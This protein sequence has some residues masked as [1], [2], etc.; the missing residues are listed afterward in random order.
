MPV[1]HAHTIKAGTASKLLLLYAREASG[2]GL[3]KTGLRH[4]TPGARAGYIREGARQARP[5]PLAPGRVGDHDPGGFVE[6]DRELLPG[7]YQFGAPD[8]L[9]AE[10]AA[11]AM[12]LLRFPGATIDPVEIHLVGYDPQDADRLGIGGLANSSRH[13]FLRRALPRLTEMELKLGEEAEHQLKEKLNTER[14]T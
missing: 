9:L 12:L 11:R 14:R 13:E 2:T 1:Q 10:G 8:E 7:V 3:P 5:V 6:V 4:D